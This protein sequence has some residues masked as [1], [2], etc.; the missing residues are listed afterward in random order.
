MSLIKFKL[1]QVRDAKLN[2]YLAMAI[3]K[4]LPL[5]AIAYSE[6]EPRWPT[7]LSFLKFK[8][9]NFLLLWIDLRKYLLFVV[10]P[11]FLNFTC[12]RIFKILSEIQRV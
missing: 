6:Y 10:A 2:S 8:K 4:K 3:S 9:S 12:K 5:K 11:V 1:T 7:N